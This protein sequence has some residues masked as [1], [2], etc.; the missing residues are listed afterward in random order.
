M[1]PRRSTIPKPKPLLDL[2]IRIL[3]SILTEYGAGAYVYPSDVGGY[4]AR[5]GSQHAHRLAVLH[6]RG[7]VDRLAVQRPDASRAR[8]RY[9][10]NRHGVRLLNDITKARAAAESATP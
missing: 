8:Y 4:D 6:D 10:L 9:A 5:K 2:D 1:T 3:T 7:L